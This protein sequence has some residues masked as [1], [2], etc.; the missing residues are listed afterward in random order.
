MA[1]KNHT[2][3]TCFFGYGSLVNAGT[4]RHNPLLRA[5]A[6]GWRR[7]WVAVP[8]RDLCFLTAVRDASG[9]IDGAI[10]PV[11]DSDWAA[12]DLRERGYD[13]HMDSA[14]ITH[15][16]AATQ[17]AIYAIPP[18]D[19]RPAG[20]QNPI[21]LSYLD[22]VIAGFADL[23]GEDHARDF[24][25]TTSGWEAP[26]LDDRADPRYPRTTPLSDDIRAIVDD[27]LRRCGSPLLAG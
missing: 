24:F 1:D 18:Q 8:W 26:V 2:A 19:C 12:L 10:A 25:V 14:N 23:Y 13:R 16:S 17:I 9:Y 3:Q 15:D 6:H 22:T 21:L 11:P 27:G 5:R 20:A 7:A 4:H